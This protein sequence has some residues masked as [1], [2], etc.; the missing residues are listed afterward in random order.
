MRF[1]VFK[2]Y[3]ND[4]AYISDANCKIWDLLACWEEYLLCLW[5][6]LWWYDDQ[7][8]EYSDNI[9]NSQNT[10]LTIAKFLSEKTIEIIHILTRQYFTDIGN[11]IKLYI[12]DIE[13]IIKHKPLTKK[14]S[15]WSQKLY[16][17]SD[18]WSIR[19]SSEIDWLF[20]A[21]D[22]ISSYPTTVQQSKLFWKIKSWVSEWLVCTHGI[23]F[24]DWNKLS[25]IYI[26]DSRRRYYKN[27][28]DPRYETL[29]VIKVMAD[30]YGA[31]LH[32]L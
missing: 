1:Y 20:E 22:I 18:S 2:N 24:Q 25:D 3:H 17:Y 23:I 5:N 12:H 27:Q 26:Y 11:V 7:K 13:S 8:S 30:I 14:K 6:E 21:I 19:N 31:N 32:V 4:L 9:Y 16:I 15:K 28:K 29:E 10:N